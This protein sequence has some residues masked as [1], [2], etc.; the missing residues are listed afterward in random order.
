MDNEVGFIA[1]GEPARYRL[2][3]SPEA[4]T[5]AEDDVFMWTSARMGY[6]GKLSRVIRQVR[7]ENG[8][9]I[10]LVERLSDAN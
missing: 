10:L 1:D 2:I 3:L 7:N 4:G 6:A 5:L 8:E 9:A